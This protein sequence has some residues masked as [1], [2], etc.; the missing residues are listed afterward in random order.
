MLETNYDPEND[1]LIISIEQEGIGK[2]IEEVDLK[3]F[4]EGIQ[5]ERARIQYLLSLI[6]DKR[7][8]RLTQMTGF[9]SFITELIVK[10]HEITEKMEVAI[11]MDNL[12]LVKM[13]KELNKTILDTKNTGKEMRYAA[14]QLEIEE[15]RLKS[16]LLEISL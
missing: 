3:E 12:N 5:S 1:I 6:Y 10:Q 8:E 13:Y 15:G 7:K 2:V 4:M 11:E 16:Q 14:K 9:M